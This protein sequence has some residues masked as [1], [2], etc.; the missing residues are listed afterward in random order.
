MRVRSSEEVLV[1]VRAE[2]TGLTGWVVAEAAAGCATRVGSGVDSGS[3]KSSVEVASG[4]ENCERGSRRVGVVTY[5]SG[6]ATCTRDHEY[7]RRRGRVRTHR[8]LLCGLSSLCL[9]TRL[10]M[11]LAVDVEGI[12]RGEDLCN[13]VCL[14]SLCGEGDTGGIEY[15]LEFG[16]FEGFAV[17][18]MRREDI[19]WAGSLQ[20]GFRHGGGWRI[21]ALHRL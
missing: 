7:G 18:E 9:G 21:D 20:F 5:S 1:K 16:D 6:S 13:E 8:G 11:K 12:L 10:T 17:C 19:I 15:F 14:V 4:L 3:S 2:Q